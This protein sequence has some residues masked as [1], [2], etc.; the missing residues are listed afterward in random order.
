MQDSMDWA[1]FGK[2]YGQ[3][4]L[5]GVIPIPVVG[6]VAGNFAISYIAW[7]EQGQLLALRTQSDCLRNVAAFA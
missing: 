5:H 6:D 2:E 4:C 1:S 7:L 3:G